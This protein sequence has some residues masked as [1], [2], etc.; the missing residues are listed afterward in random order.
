[1]NLRNFYEMQA[2]TWDGRAGADAG[3]RGRK[4]ARLF[5][6]H[7]AHVHRLLDIGCG[8]GTLGMSLKDILGAGEVY[9]IEISE[10]RV[11]AARQKGI[12]CVQTDLNEDSIPFEDNSFD[13][14]FCGEVIEHLVDPDHLLDE[15]G[16][17]LTPGGVC[18]LTTPNLAAWVNRIALFL[19]WQPFHTAVSFR[20]EVGRPRFLSSG[21]ARLDHL[22][23]FTYGALR[24]LLR[25]HHFRILEVTGSSLMD[26]F[27]AASLNSARGFFARALSPLDAILS[28]APSLSSGIIVAFGRDRDA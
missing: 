5:Q 28:R 7:V 13:A 16:R 8:V 22:R 18:V 15:I 25:L 4:I 26:G 2:K 1:M 12:K 6:K 3:R 10:T 21:G 20:H 23:V 9:G 19:G 11:A 24:E 14:I 27:D 17:T